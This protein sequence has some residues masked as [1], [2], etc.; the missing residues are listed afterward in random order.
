MKYSVLVF[1]TIITMAGAGNIFAG[2]MRPYKSPTIAAFRTDRTDTLITAMPAELQQSR[3][4][5]DDSDAAFNIGTERIPLQLP[6]NR[7]KGVCFLVV[8]RNRNPNEY[9]VYGDGRGSVKISVNGGG[10]QY[11]CPEGDLN[12]IEI[13]VRADGMLVGMP[14]EWSF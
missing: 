10:G 6:I 2:N 5:C 11:L 14:L 3:W 9:I 12:A 7:T 13:L 1:F 8:I 4:I